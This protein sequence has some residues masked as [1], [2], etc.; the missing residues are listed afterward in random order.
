M[1]EGTVGAAPTYAPYYLRYMY[2]PAHRLTF[3]QAKALPIDSLILEVGKDYAKAFPWIRQVDGWKS[4][5]MGFSYTDKGIKAD[6]FFD[7][8]EGSAAHFYLI[9][10]PGQ[11]KLPT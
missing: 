2:H 7:G 3:E 4:L 9:W 5:Y 6:G 11:E 1:G 10:L 8:G